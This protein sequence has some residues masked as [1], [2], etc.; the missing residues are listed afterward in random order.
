[1]LAFRLVF[2]AFGMHSH[3]L[4]QAASAGEIFLGPF[5]GFIEDTHIAQ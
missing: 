5:L 1:M 2:V 3:L 4:I